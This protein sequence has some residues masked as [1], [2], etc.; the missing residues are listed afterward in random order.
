MTQHCHLATATLVR[1]HAALPS[2]K[3]LRSSKQCPAEVLQK[4]LMQVQAA[5]HK[6]HQ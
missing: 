6:P 4:L 5:L 3:E 2:C 1:G